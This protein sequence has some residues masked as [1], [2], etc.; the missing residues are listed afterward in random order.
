MNELQGE[1]R[2]SKFSIFYGNQKRDCGW[3]TPSAAW[4]AV[5]LQHGMLIRLHTVSRNAFIVTEKSAKIDGANGLKK[6][7]DENTVSLSLVTLYAKQG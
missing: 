1:I 5:H 6:N 2:K 3:S 7:M 4:Y